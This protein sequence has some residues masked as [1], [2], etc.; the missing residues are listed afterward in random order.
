MTVAPIADLQRRTLRVLAGAQVIGAVGL[1][2]GATA[3]SLLA[4]DVTG[5]STASGLPLAFVVLGSTAGA[6]PVGG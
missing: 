2:S 5:G 4:E 6:V 1:S 3:G